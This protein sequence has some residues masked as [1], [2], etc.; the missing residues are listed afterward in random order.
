MN[1]SSE[2][3]D[4]KINVEQHNTQCY[5]GIARTAIKMGDMNRGM[6]IANELNDKTL[7]IEIAGVCE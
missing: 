5:A 3:L 2:V 7:V 6:Q 1:P 4:E